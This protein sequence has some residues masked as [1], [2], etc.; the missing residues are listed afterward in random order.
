MFR[1]LAFALLAAFALPAP[2]DDPKEK[3][4]DK[5]KPAAVLILGQWKL[6]KTDN[7]L[8]KGTTAVLEMKKDG[9]LTLT[10]ELDG[11]K[12]AI[13][14]TWKLDGDTK[15]TAVMKAK[16]M[17]NKTVMTIEKLTEDDFVTI[18]EGKKK[19]EFKRVKKDEEKK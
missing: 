16:G 17:E 14:G 18:D 5:P 19:D 11:E 4:K 6:H 7:E 10:M 13:E 3:P 12:Q 15:L 9:K 2:A 8:P 1:P